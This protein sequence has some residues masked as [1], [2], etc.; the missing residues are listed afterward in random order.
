MAVN[1]PSMVMDSIVAV[2]IGPGAAC[3][4]PDFVGSGFCTGNPGQADGV[5][6]GHIAAVVDVTGGAT[7]R[8]EPM[9]EFAPLRSA[10]AGE[11]VRR[12]HGFF[13]TLDGRRAC[14][15]RGC[16]VSPRAG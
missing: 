1:R 12:V 4:D 8:G 13:L 16:A 5:F 14:C 15:M 7:R 10:L 6:A 3:V 11:V 2:W 9:P